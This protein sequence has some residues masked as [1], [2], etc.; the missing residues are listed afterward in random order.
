[1][2]DIS[3]L[4]NVIKQQELAAYCDEDMAFIDSAARVKNQENVK[5]DALLMG[6]C[7]GGS[8]NVVIDSR[9]FC[10]KKDDL[11]V[12]FPGTTLV[13]DDDI[14]NVECRWIC[15]SIGCVRHLAQINIGDAWNA[16]T[17]LHESP[18]LHLLPNEVSAFCNYYDLLLS[19]LNRSH[20]R[21]QKKLVETLLMAFLYDF[22]GLLERYF[23]PVERPG[24]SSGRA[25]REFVD[26]LTSLY[27]RPRDVAFYAEKLCLT[28]KYLS[29]VCKQ[30]SGLTASKF[31][32]Q[33]IIKDIKHL[34]DDTDKSIKEICNELDFPNPSFFGTYV[35]KN[36]G[37][38]PMQYRESNK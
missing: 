26:L 3:E 15:L 7:L 21:Y 24:R 37:M 20:H 9:E 17:S 5:T 36:L 16:F 22:H 34:L 1:M 27:P 2:K 29:S 13:L 28:P 19:K 12:C 18:V 4:L 35:K 33:F 14:S 10:I 31:I 23:V 30:V 38:S 11:I 8:A 32:A 25:F 6:L